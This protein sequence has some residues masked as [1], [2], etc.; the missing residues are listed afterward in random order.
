LKKRNE[1]FRFIIERNVDGMVVKP[2]GSEGE[3]FLSK[4][5]SNIPLVLV[6]RRI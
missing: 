2:S 3:L 6:D 4:A 5:L 1:S